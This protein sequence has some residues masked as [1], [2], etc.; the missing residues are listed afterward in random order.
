MYWKPELVLSATPA[1]GGRRDDLERLLADS[2]LET[3]RAGGGDT[4]RRLPPVDRTGL[5]PTDR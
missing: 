4:V 2:G 5:L 1:G 3:R